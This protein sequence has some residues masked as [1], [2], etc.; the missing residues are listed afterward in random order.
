VHEITLPTQPSTTTWA[1]FRRLVALGAI[2]AMAQTGCSRSPIHFVL[3][4]LRDRSSQIERIAIVTVGVSVRREGIYDFPPEWAEAARTN[5]SNAIAKSFGRDT[6]FAITELD[7]NE[8]QVGRQELERARDRMAAVRPRRIEARD[9][10]AGPAAVLA[11]AAGTD[12]LLLVYAKD[13]IGSASSRLTNLGAA[14]MVAPIILWGTMVYGPEIFSDD[15]DHRVS[16]MNAIAL[17]L[18]DAR[19]GDILWFDLRFLNRGNLLDASDV[20]RRI[21]AAYAEFREATQR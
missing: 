6:R 14:A 5:L 17:C 20:D 13:S 16:N 18:V 4:E 21:G 2:T 1:G 11:N 9:C 8:A 15:P 10:L 19:Q 7:P 3:P 12:S